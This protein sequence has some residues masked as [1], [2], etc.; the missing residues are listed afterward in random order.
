MGKEGTISFDIL[1]LFDLRCEWSGT[2]SVNGLFVEFIGCLVEG[3]KKVVILPCAVELVAT[4]MKIST[5]MYGFLWFVD[6]PNKAQKSF[7]RD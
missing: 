6:S 3:L 2:S 1:G 5:Y 4:I 7:H